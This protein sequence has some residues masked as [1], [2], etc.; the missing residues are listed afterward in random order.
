MAK[1]ARAEA[2]V[3]KT[4]CGKDVLKFIIEAKYAAA[5]DPFDMILLDLLTNSLFR[6]KKY[7]DAVL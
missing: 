2:Y 6:L 7:C 1:R 5:K 4:P 3:S